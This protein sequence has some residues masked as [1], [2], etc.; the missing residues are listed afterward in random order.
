MIG[1]MDSGPAPGGA[2]RNDESQGADVGDVRSMT[3]LGRL[4][5]EQRDV[6]WWAEPNFLATYGHGDDR[7]RN[8]G[9]DWN[10]SLKQSFVLDNRARQLTQAGGSGSG[11]DVLALD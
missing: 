9:C 4:A 2:S 7:K 6:L 3:Q 1:S 8:S 11:R 10:T 5:R